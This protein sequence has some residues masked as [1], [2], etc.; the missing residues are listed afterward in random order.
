MI[1]KTK[2]TM[3]AEQWFGELVSSL[4][5]VMP[6]VNRKELPDCLTIQR[7]YEMYREACEMARDKPLRITQFRRM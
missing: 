1:L 5:N 6:D 3:D 2:R 4:A 7:V